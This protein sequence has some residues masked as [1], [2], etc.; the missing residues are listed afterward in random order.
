[1]KT[2]YNYLLSISPADKMTIMYDVSPDGSEP[3]VLFTENET[4]SHKLYGID[5]YT[6]YVRDAFHRY[7]VDGKLV[8]RH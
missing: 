6:K 7:V 8:H 2:A 3:S 4:N 5:N 1:M